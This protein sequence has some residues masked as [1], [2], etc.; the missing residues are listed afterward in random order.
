MNALT[1]S[2]CS[3]TS[4]PLWV[5][6]KTRS[7]VSLPVLW[8]RYCFLALPLPSS[9]SVLVIV[10]WSDTGLKWTGS[11]GFFGWPFSTVVKVASSSWF[12]S[13]M[14]RGPR[15]LGRGQ[16]LV[17]QVQFLHADLGAAGVEV[18]GL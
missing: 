13:L 2:V 16:P 5:V 4:S 17:G 10:Y 18:G 11:A 9:F 6:S 7:I 3:R 8:L 15:R 1:F 12:G 14:E